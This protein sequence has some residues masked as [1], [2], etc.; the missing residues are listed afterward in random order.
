MR[1]II[2]P[3]KKM[4]TDTDS[5][6]C[7][8]LPQFLSKAERLMERMREM[9]DGELKALWRCNDQIAAQNIQRL[10][11]MDLRR[12]LT[13]AL[14][15]Y[16]GI[17]YQYMA[18]GVFTR[19]ELAYVEEHLRILSGFYGLLRP[20]EGV[21]PYRLEMC[22]ALSVDKANNL[23]SYWDDQIA[24]TLFQESDCI[25]NLAS[26]EYSRCVSAYLEPEIRF[27]TCVFGERKDGRIIEK[28][29]LCKMARGEMV[30]WMAQEQIEDTERLKD[31]TGIGYQFSAVDSEPNTYVYIKG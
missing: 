25:I 21:T 5:F 8:S 17:Q 23:Y 14:L 4:K 16:V 28:G 7:H 2:S 15:S 13:P 11:T 20:F 30:R 24:S 10:R 22:A 12:G 31:F 19:Q 18:P 27:I 29:T 26:Q 1:I 6:P 9:S 3:A